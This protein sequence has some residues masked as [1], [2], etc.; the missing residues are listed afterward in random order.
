MA[1]TKEDLQAIGELMDSKLAPMQGDMANMQTDMADMQADMANIQTDMANIQTDMANIQTDMADIKKRV[2]KIEVTQE[3]EVLR[4]IRLLAEG[5]SGVIDRLNRLEE[6]PEQV[7][8]IQNTV[9]V[10]KHV[11]RE[12]THS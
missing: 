12:H 11:F 8:D 7:E 1:L 4:N 9:S 5:H 6:L 3:H 2:T 10:L